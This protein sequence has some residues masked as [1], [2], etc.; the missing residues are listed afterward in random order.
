MIKDWLA[1]ADQYLPEIEFLIHRPAG[2]SLEL[3]AGNLYW[4]DQNDHESFNSVSVA[5][6]S[7]LVSSGV[8]DAYPSKQMLLATPVFMLAHGHDPR[9]KLNNIESPVTSE[10]DLVVFDG[11]LIAGSTFGAWRGYTKVW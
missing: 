7:V 11:M 4:V 9:R 1:T 6:V 8:L 2:S 5:D 3:I 10:Y